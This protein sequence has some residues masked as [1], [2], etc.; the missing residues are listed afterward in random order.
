MRMFAQHSRLATCC[1]LLLIAIFGRAQVLRPGVKAAQT[2]FESLWRTATLD[3]GGDPDWMAIGDD[4]VWVANEKRKSVY[5]ID[6]ATNRVAA[7]VRFS[8]PPCSGLALGFGSLWVPLC[9]KSRSVA[10]VDVQNN[11][12][13]AVLPHGPGDSEGS[14]AAGGGS[15][16]IVSNN[17]GELL[18]ID[19]E[20]NAVAQRIS[21]PAGSHN[22]L[23]A[24]GIVWATGNETNQL[25]AVDATT[26]VILASIPVGPKPRFLTAGSGS[27]WTLNQGDGSI[28]R[29]SMK[30]RTVE[31]TVEAGIPGL[32]GEIAFGGGM[33]WATVRQ[34]PLTRINPESNKVERQWVGKG[35]DSVRFDFDSIWLTDLKRGLLWRIPSN[36]AIGK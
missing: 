2:S 19:P 26:G 31:A 3:L 25:T 27:I 12:I 7:R 29:V 6:P 32:G 28:T 33:V 5:R 21:L 15:V 11:R 4:A 35:G 18:R 1:F 24:D 14:I 16:W 17:R 30:A 20:R 34:I 9:G 10:R 13:V 8:D 22:L 23:F 36:E